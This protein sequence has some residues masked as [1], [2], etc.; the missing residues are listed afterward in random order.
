MV[1]GKDDLTKPTGC[2]L[3]GD[4]RATELGFSDWNRCKGKS[5]DIMYYPNVTDPYGT[6]MRDNHLYYSIPLKY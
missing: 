5:D 2:G 1:S 3:N 6:Y 4:Y